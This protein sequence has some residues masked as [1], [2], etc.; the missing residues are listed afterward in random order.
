MGQSRSDFDRAFQGGLLATLQLVASL[1][2]TQDP[3]QGNR[4]SQ[5][6]ESEGESTPKV[7]STYLS[8]KSLEPSLFTIAMRKI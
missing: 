8:G 2:A 6:P 3:T 7:D 4:K 1:L 5:S